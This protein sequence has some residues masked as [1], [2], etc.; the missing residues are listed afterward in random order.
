MINL[1]ARVV[2]MPEDWYELDLKNQTILVH[3]ITNHTDMNWHT[4][5]ALQAK[6]DNSDE[7]GQLTVLGPYYN[8]TPCFNSTV[9]LPYNIKQTTV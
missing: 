1:Y 6:Q 7:L 2:G 3:E 5:W 4:Y 8:F 9:L